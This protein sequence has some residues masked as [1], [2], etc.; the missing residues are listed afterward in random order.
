M[1]AM[2]IGADA[3]AVALGL[4]ALVTA[5]TDGSERAARVT[6]P[7]GMMVERSARALGLSAEQKAAFQKILAHEQPRREALRRAARENRRKL[8]A[9]LEAEAPDPA[10]VGTLAI[11]Q[12][13]LNESR[14]ALFDQQRETL[15][16][17]LTPEQQAKL[18]ALEALRPFG[19]GWMGFHGGGPGELPPPPHESAPD[20]P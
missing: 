19:P 6:A 13:Q 20:L 8:R 5:Q 2:S 7:G 17:L 15:R 11:E 9:A 3:L 18:D 1:K 12:H 16:A 10:A 14:R 4:A